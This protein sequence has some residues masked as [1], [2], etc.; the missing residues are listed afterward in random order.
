MKRNL[1]IKLYNDLLNLACLE[2]ELDD[3]ELVD[4]MQKLRENFEKSYL[5]LID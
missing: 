2:G 5:E 1:I 3:E 4:K